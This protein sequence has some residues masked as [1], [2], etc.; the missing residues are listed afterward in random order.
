MSLKLQETET[1]VYLDRINDAMRESWCWSNNLKQ[2][3]LKIMRKSCIT[4]TDKKGDYASEIKFQPWK[5]K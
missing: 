4:I 2:Y 3:G 5:Y 1:P